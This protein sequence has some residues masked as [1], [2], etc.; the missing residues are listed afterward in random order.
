VDG[1]GRGGRHAARPVLPTACHQDNP[2]RTGKRA[3][4]LEPGV[5]PDC[6][7]TEWRPGLGFRVVK[8]WNCGEE[9]P[10][11]VDKQTIG[12][13]GL[14]LNPYATMFDGPTFEH[15]FCPTCSAGLRREVGEAT[16]KWEPIAE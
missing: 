11:D 6:H 9:V 2:T 8:C 15:A 5:A 16:D 14:A 10:E 7:T 3:G 1:A 4:G 13:E 12:G